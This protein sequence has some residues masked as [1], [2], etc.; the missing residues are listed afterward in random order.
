MGLLRGPGEQ[1][2]RRFA[3][4]LPKGLSANLGKIESC[5]DA[6]VASGACPPGSKIG[7]VVAKAGSGFDPVALHGDVYAAGAYHGAPVSIAMVLHAPPGPFDLGTTTTR[8][9]M[10]FNPH[11]GRV[12][13]VSDPLPALVEGIPVRIQS[14]GIS[15]DRPGALRNPTSCAP[16]SFDVTAEAASG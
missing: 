2:T 3:M 5:S 15:L 6:A 12:T 7:E 9:A 16:A 1:L 11:S 8:S 14:I 13:V 4:S 10:Q